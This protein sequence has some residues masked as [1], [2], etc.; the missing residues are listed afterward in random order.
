[1]SRSFFH[2]SLVYLKHQAWQKLYCQAQLRHKLQLQL[3]LEKGAE[4]TIQSDTANHI[5]SHLEVTWLSKLQ[6]PYRLTI[7]KA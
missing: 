1:M 6:Q 7:A 2:G 4:L 3:Q 5:I